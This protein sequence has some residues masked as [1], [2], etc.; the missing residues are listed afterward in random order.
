MRKLYITIPFILVFV[1]NFFACSDDDNGGDGINPLDPGAP[2][3]ISFLIQDVDSQFILDED[4]DLMNIEKAKVIFEGE[5]LPLRGNPS[6][7]TA[8]CFYITKGILDNNTGMHTL[9]TIRGLH[10]PELGKEYKLTLD[11]GSGLTDE[12]RF[13]YKSIALGGYGMDIYLNGEICKEG[14]LVRVFKPDNQID[15]T[16][17]I[18]D[19]V[20]QSYCLANFDKNGDGRLTY[21]ETKLVKEIVMPKA[22]GNIV[23]DFSA[24]R[25]FPLLEKLDIS[26]NPIKDLNLSKN[27]ILRDFTCDD[28]TELNKLILPVSDSLKVLSC[29]STSLDSLD[30][31][32]NKG[33]LKVDCSG[34][35]S[36]L[37]ELRLPDTETLSKLICNGNKLENLNVSKNVKLKLL[38]C[39]DNN[40]SKLYVG[41]NILEELY[42]AKN[43]LSQ[44]EIG[45]AES[46]VTLHCNDN[47]LKNLNLSQ[48]KMLE[49]LHSQN[50]SF[51]K[52]DISNNTRLIELN[53]MNNKIDTISV[54]KEFNISDP[55]Q[56]LTAGVSKDDAAVFVVK[57]EEEKT[58]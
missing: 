41:S 14:Q 39:N 11:L 45:S 13:V 43:K 18:E 52:L 6:S 36:R 48:N 1:F 7:D 29:Q 33:L 22:M 57:K 23:T 28:C 10:N 53:C 42:C 55:K 40:L 4:L 26:G 54:W 19:S 3:R 46:L 16:D 17:K 32:K 27:I 35:G 50:N 2:N 30:L 58:K 5:E 25:C 24:I 51:S 12:I 31:S 49:H 8:L 47:L 34:N 44:L 56:T 38:N 21:D 20:L 15:V 37:K 9:L